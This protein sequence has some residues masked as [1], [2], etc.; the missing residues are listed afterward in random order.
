MKNRIVQGL[1]RSIAVLLAAV[2]TVSIFPVNS[3][4]TNDDIDP[5]IVVSLGDSYSSGEGIEP[6]YGQDKPIYQKVNDDDWLAHR[7]ELSWPSQLEIPGLAG[8]MAD[9]NVKTTSSSECQWYFVAASGAETKHL[10]NVQ[11]KK[12][13][14][15]DTNVVQVPLP[16]QLKVFD[17]IDGT[18]DYVT[19]TIGGNDVDFAGII[20]ACASGSSY[21]DFNWFQKTFDQRIDDVWSNI[22]TTKANI[23]QAYYDIQ[24]AAGE[25]AAIIVAG[26]PKLLDKDGKGVLISKE[27]A[28][29]INKNVT[30]FN[31]IIEELVGECS[32]EGMNIWYVNVEDAFD[33]HEAYSS[34][35]WIREIELIKH[36]EDLDTTFWPLGSAYSVHPNEDG[37]KAYADCVNKK[38]EYIEKT[39]I[40]GKICKAL[41]RV[42][43]ISG[44]SINIY[45][46]ESLYYTSTA[47][48]TGNYS[49]AL[50]VGE[51]RIEITADGYIAFTA[52]ATVTENNN[53]YMETFLMVEGSENETGIA[54]GT[55]YNALTGSGIEGV[56]LTVRSGWNNTGIGDVVA[57]TTTGLNGSYSVTLPLGNYTMYATKD[58]YIS[59]AINIIVQEGTTSAQDGTMTPVI[60]GDSFRI[61]LT[62]GENPYD[63]DSHVVGTLSSG[64]SFHVYYSNKSQYDGDVEV[65]NLDVDDVT[66]YGPETITL[67]TTTENPYYY[68]I[69]RYAGS[70]TVASSSAQVKVY[71]G[72]NLVATF[73]VP[74]DQGDGDYW[75]VFA[76]VN[77][78]L[79]VKNTITS[80]EDTSYATV[81]VNA[82]S[83]DPSEDN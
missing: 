70:G 39:R 56:S 5:I 80:S 38:I 82:L 12:I 35:P 79:V 16:A 30:E 40:S 23:K 63:L 31:K 15:S 69:Y 27:E 67:N 26:Y 2:L 51:Y 49:I 34:D 32:D 11:Q 13:N 43:P 74:T 64:G 6:F 44:A 81:A 22:N 52:Y 61:V 48:D 83:V 21:L 46:N 19:L 62:W 36:S 78:E 72:E 17:S 28:T 76:I 1:A 59:A 37:A 18:V 24:D 25:K 45:K 71:Q 75:N 3:Y 57:T 65:C 77:G 41:D 42:T 54:S 8:T 66:S 14:R 33:G 60:L 50:P 29:T 20:T 4:A 58:G 10:K 9:Y 47:D 7:S 53:T 55:I 68:Y 73:N